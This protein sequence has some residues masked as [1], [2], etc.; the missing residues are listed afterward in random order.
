MHCDTLL[1]DTPFLPISL[2]LSLTHTHTHTHTLPLFFARTLALN[3]ASTNTFW[4]LRSPCTMQT[5][6]AACKNR[7]P[8]SHRNAS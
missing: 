1:A 4:A 7:I 3:L 2:P 5:G 8:C 6:T